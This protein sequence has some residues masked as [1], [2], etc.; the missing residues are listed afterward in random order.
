MADTVASDEADTRPNDSV[1]P[2][3]EAEPHAPSEMQKH[4]VR[5]QSTAARSLR[6]GFCFFGNAIGIS[7]DHPTR[8]GRFQI[9]YIRWRCPRMTETQ[10]AGARSLLD[11]IKHLSRIDTESRGCLQRDLEPSDLPLSE[12]MFFSTRLTASR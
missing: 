3:R 9:C 12:Q 4:R 6:R 8:E 5:R 1:G 7:V 10:H 11:I 2:S